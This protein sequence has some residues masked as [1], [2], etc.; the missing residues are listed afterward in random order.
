MIERRYDSAYVEN[1]KPQMIYYDVLLLFKV[2]LH[3]YP[4]RVKML[5]IIALVSIGVA[6][7]SWLT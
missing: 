5:T 1:Q 3:F 7:A 2:V 4:Q 6:L